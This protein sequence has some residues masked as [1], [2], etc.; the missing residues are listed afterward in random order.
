MLA[1]YCRKCSVRIPDGAYFCSV[2]GDSNFLESAQ[3]D[4]LTVPGGQEAGNEY[5]TILEDP[6]A[7]RKLPS[8]SRN[9]EPS[10]DAMV[11]MSDFNNTVD[12]RAWNPPDKD[13]TSQLPW[14][15]GPEG[16]SISAPEHTVDLGAWIPQ[17][18]DATSQFPQHNGEAPGGSTL[19]TYI[20]GVSEDAPAGATPIPLTPQDMSLLLEDGER[21][22][23]GGLIE[24]RDTIAAHPTTPLNKEEDDN[25]VRDEIL[26]IPGQ[27]TESPP[28][29]ADHRQP[30]N[31]RADHRQPT[32]MRADHKQPTNIRADHKQPGN[33]RAAHAR[34][35][36]FVS[37]RGKAGKSA[38]SVQNILIG[39][40][41]L[42]IT[43]VI[44][45]LL[46]PVF[47]PQASSTGPKISLVNATSAF[48]GGSVKLHG[49]NF[50]PGA[51]VSFTVD[52]TPLAQTDHPASS[53][54]PL[55]A[56]LSTALFSD[57]YATRTETIVQPNGTFDSMIDI[58][59]SWEVN[60]THDIQASE[61]STGQKALVKVTVV[62]HAKA[63]IL[64]T[65]IATPNATSVV[66]VDGTPQPG[67][68]PVAITEDPEATPAPGATEVP[69]PTQAPQLTATPTATPPCVRMNSTT[70]TFS[71]TVGG[72][73]PGTQSVTAS[74]GNGCGAG[75]WSV[76][77]DNNW[78]TANQSSTT[79]GVNGTARVSVGVK[80]GN[81]K[82]GTYTG[83]VRLGSGTGVVTVNLTVQQLPT[84]ITT[85]TGL[86]SFT[87]NSDRT[88]TN[89]GQTATIA[90]GANCRAGTWTVASDAAWLSVTI[91]RGTIASGGSANTVVNASTIGLNT[92][93]TTGHLTF[94][95]PGSDSQ[96]LP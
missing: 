33:M 31:M 45:I 92:G 67:E 29:R 13:A 1:M 7:G 44:V 79:I 63:T 91:V 71:A 59:S 9:R 12:M 28:L 39:A 10:A 68:T 72:G 8:S 83:H 90:N 73:A 56:S 41:T 40:S 58:P 30:M 50:T 27:F 3:S 25:G 78:L 53:F 62:D 19:K 4:D 57:A 14:Q 75:N 47:R 51:V 15:N 84:C 65:P 93:T 22:Q 76:N 94:S 49:I 43:G 38:V 69:V 42:V 81:L 74:N 96:Q 11:S 23:P 5:D 18:E 89:Q 66:N 24:N 70:L 20:Y 95:A 64:P 85:K 77:T 55:S 17:N 6:L 54:S 88:V 86:L 21:G 34:P 37:S 36:R 16:A 52:G 2:C 32:N 80:I 60:S 46:L 87:A 48:P 35:G 61:S 82:A 26:F